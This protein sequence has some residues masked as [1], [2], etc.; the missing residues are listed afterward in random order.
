MSGLHTQEALN[1][2]C[3]GSYDVSLG[4]DWL[5][6]HKENLNCRDETLE[7]EDVEGN[8]R[9]LQGIHKRVSVI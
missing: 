1:I 5:V 4:M 9:V 6:F 3:L 8:K 2:V 7:F